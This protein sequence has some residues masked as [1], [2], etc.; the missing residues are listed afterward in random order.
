MNSVWLC[1]WSF[2]I[3]LEVEINFKIHFPHMYD[4]A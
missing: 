4:L 3:E 2:K 1:F